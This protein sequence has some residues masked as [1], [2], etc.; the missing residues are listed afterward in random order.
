MLG[1]VR[2]GVAPDHPEVKSVIKDFEKVAT[3]SRFSFLGNITVGDDV[4]VDELRRYYNAIVLAYGATDDRRLNI[5][6]ENLLG[7]MAAR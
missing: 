4:S 5:P 2:S 6:G 1:L 7:G 3:D